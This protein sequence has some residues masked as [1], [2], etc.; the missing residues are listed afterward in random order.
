MFSTRFGRAVIFF[1]TSFLLAA[2]QGVFASSHV[3]IVRLSD[4]EGTVHIDRATGQGFEK[5][6]MNMPVTQGVRLRTDASGRAEIEFENGTVLRLADNSAV[7]FTDLSLGSDGQRAT[8][9]HLDQGTVYVDYKHKGGDALSLDAANESI[10]PNA[11]VHF[12]MQLDGSNARIAV[13]RGELEV[14]GNGEMAKLKKG[15]T[16]NLDLSNS[17]NDLLAKSISTLP[18]DQWDTERTSYNTQ[19]AANYNRNQVPYMYGYSGLNYY[20]SFFS[21]PG[22]G[23]LWQP[24]GVSAL[25]D[26]FSAGAWAFYPGAGYMW[27]SGYPWG[28][29]PYRYGSWVYASGFGWAWQPGGWGAY[30]AFPV[31]LNAPPGWRQPVPPPTSG[32]IRPT[33][34]VGTP[35]TAR[36]AMGMLN[37][38]MRRPNVPLNRASMPPMATARPGLPASR[39]SSLP[40]Q[41]TASTHPSVPESPSMSA[42][43]AGS[44]S[45]GRTVVRH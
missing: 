17:S 43:P 32:G 7:Q 26:P 42:P 8:A 13:F 19:Y 24:F 30:S 37:S 9:V 45:S 28:W 39:A 35:V 3:R 15:E 33:I 6:I 38:T 21:V 34:V 29:T 16:F 36:P 20:G 18:A 10:K 25:W 11:D 2:A 4:I 12:R 27:V 22:Y 31:I 23:M 14:P 44:S 1:A 5:A 41:R 40:S